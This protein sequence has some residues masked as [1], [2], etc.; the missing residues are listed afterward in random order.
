MMAGFL[1]E[2]VMSLRLG[3]IPIEVSLSANRIVT[4]VYEIVC[5]CRFSGFDNL[6]V[7]KRST[8]RSAGNRTVIGKV[9]LAGDPIGHPK[10]ITST[11]RAA[12]DN[13]KPFEQD[14][15][16]HPFDLG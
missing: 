11:L 4:G 16:K 10:I 7:G 15:Y 9:T 14:T 6:G 5:L 8:T 1:L 3:V 12:W 2:I 13:M